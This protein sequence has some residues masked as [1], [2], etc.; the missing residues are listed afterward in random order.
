MGDEHEG[1]MMERMDASH[2]PSIACRQGTRRHGDGA[3]RRTGQRIATAL[4]AATLLVVALQ[5]LLPAAPVAAGEPFRINLYHRN[6]FV[7]QATKKQCVAGAMQ[8]MLNIALPG[9]DGSAAFQKRLANLAKKLS[10]ARDGGTE[11]LGWAR[12]LE[13]LGAGPYEV[14][15]V[16]T[17]KEAVRVAAQALR[18]TR[19]PVGLLAWRGAHAWVMHGFV[20]DADPALTD[21]FTVS[22]LYISDPWYPRISSIW[23]ASNPPNT[24][25]PVGRLPEDYKPW[26]RPTAKYPDMDGRYVLVVPVPVVLEPASVVGVRVVAGVRLVPA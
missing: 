2:D 22:G 6:D 7:S 17:R 8:T 18:E 11:P 5:T 3:P 21:E 19:R 10:E 1:G 16:D 24:L 25:V 12:G 26:R 4:A 20:A 13:E 15:V 9:N 14:R 23:G